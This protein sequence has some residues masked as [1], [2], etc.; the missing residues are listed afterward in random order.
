MW[1]GSSRARCTRSAIASGSSSDSMRSASTAN[2]SPPN[3]A[4]VSRSR[5]VREALGDVP[6]QLVAGGVP[7]RV[8]DGL[9]VVEVDEQHREKLAVAMGSG[10]RVR[11]S[12]FEQRPVREMR[13]GIVER[14]VSQLGFEMPAL[15]EAADHH[16]RPA[17]GIVVA[18]VQRGALH[19]QIGA[20]GVAGP[21]LTERA[22]LRAGSLR[23]RFLDGRA[24]VRMREIDER[25]SDDLIDRVGEH[26]LHRRA[27]VPDDAGGVEDQRD[28]GRVLQQR[29]GAPLLPHGAFARTP[30]PEGP[31]QQGRQ[32]EPEP[33][34]PH[35]QPRRVG[36]RG[37]GL[38]E[39]SSR[40]VAALRER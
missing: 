32:P 39:S 38:V 25:R 6:Q 24:L 26:R 16:Q 27:G 31:H 37:I 13:Q 11:H 7:E 20:G 22:T 17:D 34:R 3:R 29:V 14:L 23:D 4:A 9:E 15:A 2:S 1:N 19:V 33:E 5:A 28:I 35:R 40:A 8:V 18:T 12:V 10:D 21:P 36:V 30:G